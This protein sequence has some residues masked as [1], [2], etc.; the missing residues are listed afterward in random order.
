MF[1]HNIPFHVEGILSDSTLMVKF[2]L[3]V[4]QNQYNG[5]KPN[6]QWVL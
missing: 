5:A 2:A 4:C 6:I 1:K 3:K